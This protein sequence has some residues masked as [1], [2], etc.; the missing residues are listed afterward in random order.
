[1][2]AKFTMKRKNHR[3]WLYCAIFAV[4]TLLLYDKDVL[5]TYIRTAV[6]LG[7]KT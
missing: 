1:M 7:T 5:Y 2:Q 4:N 6:Y 3:Q